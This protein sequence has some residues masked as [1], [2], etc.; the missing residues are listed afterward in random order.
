MKRAPILAALAGSLE[1]VVGLRFRSLRTRITVLYASLFVVVLAAIVSLAGSGLNQFAE[2]AATRD[3]AANARVFDDILA[4]RGRQMSTQAEVLARDFGFRGAVGTGDTPTIASALSSL[5][6]R[7]R[8]DTAFVMT[9]EGEVLTA[10]EDEIAATT[11]LLAR[12]EQGESQGI[13]VSDEGLALAAAAPIEAPDLIG[14]LVISQRLNRA[15][16]DRL[17]ELAPIA[18]EARVVQASDLPG[19]LQSAGV[20]S[21]TRRE[22]TEPSLYYVAKLAQ[23]QDGIAPR[24]VLRH[25]LEQSLAEFARIKGLLWILSGGALCWCFA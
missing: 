20:G 5:Q 13:I 18:L 22:K 11:E 12:L 25:S 19:W 24:L 21:V 2:L 6:A 7:A 15:E 1:R 16:L 10:G 9:L 23:L 17:V 3:L 4:T 14:W 8:S